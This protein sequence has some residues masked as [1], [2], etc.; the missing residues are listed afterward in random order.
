MSF[1]EETGRTIENTVEDLI[2]SQRD[3]YYVIKTASG[4]EIGATAEHPF[5]TG[6]TTEQDNPPQ[7]RMQIFWDFIKNIPLYL[8]LGWQ[9]VF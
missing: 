3:E 1:D 9:E 6:E 4:K 7:T 5:Y 2:V 8:R